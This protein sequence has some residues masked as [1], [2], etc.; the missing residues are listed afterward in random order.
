MTD[1]ATEPQAH[2]P[3]PDLVNLQDADPAEAAQIAEDLAD[4]LG[5]DLEGTTRTRPA[6]AQDP[7]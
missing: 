2:E 1:R 7:S 6:S 4:R 3:D 5:Q